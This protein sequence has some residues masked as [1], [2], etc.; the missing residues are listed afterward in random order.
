MQEEQCPT[1]FP[2][3]LHNKYKGKVV[4]VLG[5]GPSVNDY[6]LTDPF[7][8]ENVT[9]GSNQIG[10]LFRPDYYFIG[11]PVAYTRYK[12]TIM[13]SVSKGSRLVIGPFVKKRFGGQIRIP[14]LS[15]DYNMKDKVGSPD[16]LRIY[17]GRTSGVIMLHMAYHMGFKYVFML[18]IDGYGVQGRSHFYQT[19]S[20]R[21]SSDY[22]VSSCLRMYYST[23]VSEDRHVF[24]L[25]HRTVFSEI[26]KWHTLDEVC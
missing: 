17:H 23:M 2:R 25:S 22:V 9:I 4:I 5:N 10:L 14:T 26:P 24:D 7:F 13:T 20:K 19:I 1:F 8:K 11:D 18:G 15:L 3:Q 16:R 12:N 6:D 21:S